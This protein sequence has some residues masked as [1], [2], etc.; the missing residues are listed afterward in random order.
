MVVQKK[1]RKKRSQTISTEKKI[2]GNATCVPR[3]QELYG[4]QNTK[5][6]MKKKKKT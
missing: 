2:K 6:K 5:D 4:H 1:K 3:Y